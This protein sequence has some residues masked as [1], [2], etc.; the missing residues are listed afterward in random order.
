MTSW[1]MGNEHRP[2]ACYLKSLTRNTFAKNTALTECVCTCVQG[3][4]WVGQTVLDVEE[5]TNRVL[6]SE[7][8]HRGLTYHCLLDYDLELVQVTNPAGVR[9][10]KWYTSCVW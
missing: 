6:P 8:S 5:W 9:E 2:P 3:G 7:M 10:C 4:V 1:I